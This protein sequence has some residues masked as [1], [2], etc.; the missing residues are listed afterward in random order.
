MLSIQNINLNV[1]FLLSFQFLFTVL[2]VVYCYHCSAIR[3][4]IAM[5]V[6]QCMWR[7]GMCEHACNM[8]IHVCV[9]VC[10]Y[11][12]IFLLYLLLICLYFCCICVCIFCFLCTDNMFP[13]S[14]LLSFFLKLNFIPPFP[15]S[16]CKLPSLCV[17]VILFWLQLFFTAIFFIS[18]AIA[19]WFYMCCCCYYFY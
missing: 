2:A 8:C 7:R 3:I 15:C 5:Y 12:Y 16:L 11:M 13:F 10:V 17:C 9:Y 6:C 14:L 18:V 1:L 19:V 4:F